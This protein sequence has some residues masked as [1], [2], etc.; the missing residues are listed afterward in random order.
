[1]SISL[2]SQS[3]PGTLHAACAEAVLAV[4][5]SLHSCG[6]IPSTCCPVQPLH[7][8]DRYGE[9]EL[10]RQLWRSLVPGPKRCFSH[11]QLSCAGVGMG[12]LLQAVLVW[13]Q[14]AVLGEASCLGRTLLFPNLTS[15][16]G[17]SRAAK[18]V[19]QCIATIQGKWWRSNQEVL[20][21][22]SPGWS[23]TAFSLAGIQVL[24]KMDASVVA[25]GL[26]ARKKLGTEICH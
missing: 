12:S 1:M 6:S 2:G 8:L 19:G 17:L 24:W 3:W 20:D 9:A 13:E 25:F 5:G 15:K 21:G 16:A 14:Q 11:K 10:V 4:D 22:R 18:A 26:M 7:L 23:C